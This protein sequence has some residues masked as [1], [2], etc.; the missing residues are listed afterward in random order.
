MLRLFVL[1]VFAFFALIAVA[2]GTVA[3]AA[4]VISRAHKPRGEM[5]DV[6]GHRLR[7]VCEGR[8]RMEDG[9]VVLARVSASGSLFSPAAAS[10]VQD[11]ES[12]ARM[13]P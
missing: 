3:V 1:S 6:G 11:I 8:A 13:T 10:D 12:L 4:E 9:R 7:L 5:V 2:W